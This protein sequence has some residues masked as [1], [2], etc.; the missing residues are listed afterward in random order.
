MRIIAILSL[1]ILFPLSSCSQNEKGE[2]APEIELKT[3]DNQDFKLSDL[4]GTVVLL[5]FWATWCA[6]C[7]KEQ[8]ELIEL[9]EEINAKKKKRKFEIV[10]ISLDNKFEDWKRGVETLKIPW[11]QVSD[12]MFWQSPVAADYNLQS[13]PFNLLLDEEGYIIAEN[14]HG[15]ELRKAVLK[16]IQ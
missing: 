11:T 4:Q 14:L 16:A 2:K 6:P 5:D 12:L 1:F 7:V 8:P 9:Y 3:I 13:L 10:G 15:E